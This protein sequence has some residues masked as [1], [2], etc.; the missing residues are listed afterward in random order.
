MNQRIKL[1]LP[2]VFKLRNIKKIIKQ[3][4]DLCLL[5]R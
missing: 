2:L 1:F 5:V 4:P 3:T